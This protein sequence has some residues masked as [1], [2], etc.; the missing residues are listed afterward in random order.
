MMGI[1]SFRD[2]QIPRLSVRAPYGLSSD[3][4]CNNL[5]SSIILK[6]ILSHLGQ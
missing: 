6:L 5:S 3:G 1:R 2:K 4:G